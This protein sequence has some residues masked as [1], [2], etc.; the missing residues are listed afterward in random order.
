[1]DASMLSHAKNCGQK[2]IST[3]VMAAERTIFTMS[4]TVA[5]SDTEPFDEEPPRTRVM[6]TVDAVPIADRAMVTMLSI[7]SALPTAAAGC[8]P[9]GASMN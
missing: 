6:S 8:V 4:A 2:A 3:A 7:C 9:S 5:I 1:M